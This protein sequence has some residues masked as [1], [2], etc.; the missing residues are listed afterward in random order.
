MYIPI[1]E[2]YSYLLILYTCVLDIYIYIYNVYHVMDVVIPISRFTIVIE[3]Q[4]Q[5]GHM[6]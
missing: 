2:V 4:G 6:Q 5:E 1:E 3:L